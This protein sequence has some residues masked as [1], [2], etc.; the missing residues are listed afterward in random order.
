MPGY[1]NVL[2]D[3]TALL[4]RKVGGRRLAREYRKMMEEAARWIDLEENIRAKLA[5]YVYDLIRF[6]GL[7][8]AEKYLSRLWATYKKD[9]KERGHKA[10]RAVL[11]SLYKVM[12]IKDEVYVAQLLTSE[13]KFRRDRERFQ[14]DESRGDKVAYT[15]FNR[16]RFT[17][18]GRNLEFDWKSR[19][20]QLH[21]MKHLRILR[22]LLPDWHTEEKAFRSWYEALVD[23]FNIFSSEESYRLYTEALR[24]PEEVRGYREIRSAKM[25]EARKKADGLMGQIQNQR[26]DESSPSPLRKTS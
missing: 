5:Q 6:E 19:N 23:G 14:I 9:Q 7:A 17:V 8:Y 20:W 13:E 18:F 26:S 12:I 1:R 24:L 16:P 11:E 2:E 25:A 22:R 15:H 10:T 21:I 3:K 4:R